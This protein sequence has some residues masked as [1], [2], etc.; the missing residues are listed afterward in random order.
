M[1]LFSSERVPEPEVMQTPEEALGYEETASNEY[2]DRLD[3][4]FVDHVISIGIRGTILD[5]GTGPGQIPIKL[6]K[7]DPRIT[8][9]GIDLS[10]EMLKRAAERARQ[11][12]VS[13]RVS[14]MLASAGSIP[15]VSGSI[16]L[17]ICNS[18]LHHFSDP[19]QVFNEAHRVIKDD[20]MAYFRDLR[21][22]SRLLHGLHV[23]FFGRKYKGLMRKSFEDSVRAAYTRSELRQHIANS[24]LSNARVFYP[25]LSHIVVES[26]KH[27]LRD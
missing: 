15:V 26:Q 7:R 14:F 9:I 10:R 24:N 21:R 20:G 2:L 22:R 12:Q 18:T 25:D 5:L 4:Q 11:E 17:L 1:W 8:V 19:V 16:D 27:T 3:N 23:A 6:A 13:S